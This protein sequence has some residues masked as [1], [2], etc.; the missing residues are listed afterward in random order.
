MTAPTS[1]LGGLLKGVSARG[2]AV[3]R[4]LAPEPVHRS[5]T[6]AK[7]EEAPAGV[8]IPNM[9]L[10][11]SPNEVCE[12]KWVRDITERS[13][14]PEEL[15]TTALQRVTDHH[16]ERPLLE[17]QAIINELART[18]EHSVL[19]HKHLGAA[20]FHRVLGKEK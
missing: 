18:G 13:G 20:Q 19:L 11:L 9:R 6:G 4:A 14:S 3:A 17:A 12:R 7:R 1:H 10:A 16:A 5:D 15:L 2:S 8:K